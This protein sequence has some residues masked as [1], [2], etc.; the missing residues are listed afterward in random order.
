[1]LAA[2]LV[3]VAPSLSPVAS[4]P[5]AAQESSDLDRAIAY[6]MR[7]GGV[8]RVRY[9]IYGTNG[10]R[11]SWIPMGAGRRFCE[12]TE[13]SGAQPPTSW[14]SLPVETLFAQTPT[15][16]TLAYL[17]PPPVPDA[18]PS[19]NPASNFCSALGGSDLWGGVSA[20]GG[21]W[22]TLDRDTPIDILQACAF[23]D[24]SLIDSWGIT[25]HAGGV[26]RGADLT[27]ILNYQSPNPPPI[28][29]SRQAAKQ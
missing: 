7:H 16:A 2:I 27:P 20:A 9:P 4:V 26:I 28:F 17:E 24:G 22:V 21:G 10:A 19:V 8:V 1:M 13:G 12:F 23:A 29:R 14:I 15:L 5:A 18:P 6:C 25:Y 11:E 3:C